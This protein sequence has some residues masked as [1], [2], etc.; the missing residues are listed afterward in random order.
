V[1]DALGMELAASR[2]PGPPAC[3]VRAADR[4]S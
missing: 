2:R 1:T 3:Q 4:V